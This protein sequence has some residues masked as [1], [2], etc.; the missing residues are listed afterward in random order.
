[1]EL[2]LETSLEKLATWSTLGSEF[3]VNHFLIIHYV[4]TYNMYTLYFIMCCIVKVGINKVMKWASRKWLPSSIALRPVQPEN[5]SMC[6]T[7]D[8]TSADP[9]FPSGHSWIMAAVTTEIFLECEDVNNRL[10]VASLIMTI[11]TVWSRVF[12]RCHTWIQVGAGVLTGIPYGILVYYATP[13]FL[14]DDREAFWG[15]LT[16]SK[17]AL[18][19]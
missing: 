14:H 2:A 10:F 5:C 17:Y 15:P 3:F 16:T 19:H 1:M 18:L 9:G 4:L 8:Y 7:G 6:N 11:L 13:E 12:K